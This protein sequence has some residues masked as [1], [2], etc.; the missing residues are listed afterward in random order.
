MNEV[1][2]AV[3]WSSREDDDVFT[4]DIFGRTEDGRSVHV[5]TDFQPYFFVKLMLG[6]AVP[7]I[8]TLIERPTLIKRK[9]LWGFQNSNEH[10]FAKLTFR[11]P[12]DMKR[13]EW[14]CRNQ[15]YQVY[16][17]NLDPILRLMHRTGIQSTGWLEAKGAPA[18][19]STCAVDIRVADWR[20]LKPVDRDDIAPL[21]IASLD[22][23]C[24]SDSGAFPTAMNTSDTCSRWP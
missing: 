14:M 24:Y 23:E 12:S 21:R 9:D 13:A 7:H 17:A 4:I 11:T 3:A 22:I 18:S 5:E 20:T 16:E 1:F 10:T 8:E 6:K 19:S 2:Q 15:K